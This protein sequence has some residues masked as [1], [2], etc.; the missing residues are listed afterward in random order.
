MAMTQQCIQRHYEGAW[1]TQSDAATNLRDIAYSSPIEDAIVYPLYRQM[2]AD[3]RLKATGGDVLD[4]GS[5][6]GRWIRFFLENFSPKKLV[7]ADYTQGSI[8]LLNKWFP[9]GSAPQTDLSF[10]LADITSPT[11]D[12]GQ[13]FDLINIANVLFHIP[14]A[15]LFNNAIANLKK[16][17]KRDGMIVTTEYLPRAPV[18]TQWMLVRDRYHFEQTIKQAGLRIVAIKAFN[19]FA[20]DPMGIEGPDDGPRGDFNK[21]R[22]MIRSLGAANAASAE[23]TGFVINFLTEIEKAILHFCADRIPDI[24]MPSQKLVF[25]APA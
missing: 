7:G 9:D 16:H 20:N 4:I 24:E 19:I 11:L 22:A 14:E 5:G 6:A 12:F 3:L 25:L 1:K 18:R 8:D 10:R 15:D 13:Q 17:V 21:V 2:I 23:T